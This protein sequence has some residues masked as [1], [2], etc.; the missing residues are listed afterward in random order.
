MAAAAAAKVENHSLLR[1]GQPGLSPR[2]KRKP[3]P[4][5]VVM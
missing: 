4:R 5:T 2:S 1:M 3:T